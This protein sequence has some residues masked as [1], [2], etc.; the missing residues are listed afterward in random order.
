MTPSTAPRWRRSSCACGEDI[1]GGECPIG[2]TPFAD[3]ASTN[4]HAANIACLYNLGITQGVTATE[5]APRNRVTASQVSRFLLRTYERQ[6]GFVP[7]PRIGTGRGGRV[8]GIAAR[9]PDRGRRPQ[10]P[11]RDQIADGGL[12]GRTLAQPRV[13]PAAP[14]TRRSAIRPR[15]PPVSRAL[16]LLSLTE[17][18]VAPER[19]TGY[20]RDLFE[21]WKDLDGDGCDTRRE[22]LIRD[23][24]TATAPVG[25]RACRVE[26]GLW[27]SHYDGVW[28]TD[29]S[30]ID[31]DHLVPLAEAWASGA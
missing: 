8:P 18:T 29:P 1:L 24:R 30:G 12:H 17:V 22:V 25:G 15:P 20:S 28:L 2:D 23:S 21:H 19:N 7:R 27:Y 5:F 6:G 11:A 14:P 13:R 3:V 16:S 31:I 10:R 4:T 9:N 26:A